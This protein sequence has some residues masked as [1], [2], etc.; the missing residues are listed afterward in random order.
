MVVLVARG[1]MFEDKDPGIY[2]HYG[3]NEVSI[4]DESHGS[5]SINNSWIKTIAPKYSLR[6][7]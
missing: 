3:A 5:N 2:V 7:K 6:R 1:K 4:S